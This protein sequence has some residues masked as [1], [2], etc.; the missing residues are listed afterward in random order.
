MIAAGEGG[1]V[2]PELPAT[3]ADGH[4][5]HAASAVLDPYAEHRDRRS[6]RFLYALNP[7]AKL[8]APL[9]VMVIVMFS[10]GIA[11]PLAFIVFAAAVLLIGARLSGRA[12]AA[13]LLGVPVAALVLGVTFGIWIDPSSVAGLPG[14]CVA[15]VSIGYWDL[16]LAA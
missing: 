12:I 4:E 10:R 3:P 11:L 5:G 1:A 6:S 8:A 2:T 9:P 14:A 7:L 13:L 16:T 15:L